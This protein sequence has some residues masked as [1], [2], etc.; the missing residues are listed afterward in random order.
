M[1]GRA[2]GRTRTTAGPATPSAG[3]RSTPQHTPA[4]PSR[5]RCSAGDRRGARR[6]A[7][8]HACAGMRERAWSG[9]VNVVTQHRARSTGTVV[10]VIDNASSGTDDPNGWFNLCD[11]HGGHC[12]L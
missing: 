8:G 6:S 3:D 9:A 12:E 5:Q 11:D 7:A 4:H 10:L 2:M 1:A